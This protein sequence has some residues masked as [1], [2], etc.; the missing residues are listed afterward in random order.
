M[1]VSREY[2]MALCLT[3][4]ELKKG[5]DSVET[6]VAIEALHNQGVPPQYNMVFHYLYGHFISKIPPFYD[7]ITI[8]KREVRLGDD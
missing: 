3:F 7:Y 6:G 4:I 2:K 8:I 5:F 1:E